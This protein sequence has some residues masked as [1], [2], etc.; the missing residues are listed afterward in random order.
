MRSCA[1]MDFKNIGTTVHFMKLQNKL[2]TGN[3]MFSQ[4][5]KKGG[6]A[7]FIMCKRYLHWIR[8][9]VNLSTIFSWWNPRDWTFHLVGYS[10]HSFILL[11]S[12][13]RRLTESGLSMVDWQLLKDMKPPRS[14]QE[15]EEEFERYKQYPEYQQ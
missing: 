3:Y 5:D 12:I 15:W 8:N 4:L 13:L 6:I 10:V 7:E 2:S 9:L 14:Q 11:P 1:H